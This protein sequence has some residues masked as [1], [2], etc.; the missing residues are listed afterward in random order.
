MAVWSKLFSS[1]ANISERSFMNDREQ[2]RMIMNV[3]RFVN[4]LHVQERYI[5]WNFTM[6]E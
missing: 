1:F 4:N 2:L 5:T 6:T 3:E